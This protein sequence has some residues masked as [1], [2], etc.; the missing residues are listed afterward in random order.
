MRPLEHIVDTE[1][2]KECLQMSNQTFQFKHDLRAHDLAKKLEGILSEVF[3]T[4]TKI[5]I[6]W[7]TLDVQ[8]VRPDLTEDEAMKVLL[9]VKDNHDKGIGINFD[10]IK[11]QCS[12]LFP[13]P[14]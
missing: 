13:V 8:Y 7:D 10:V 4:K 2:L 9:Y 11:H 3:L 14:Q 1:L 12:T 6:E 5:F